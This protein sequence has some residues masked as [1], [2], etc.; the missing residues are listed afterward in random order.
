[1]LAMPRCLERLDGGA[2]HADHGVNVDL[3]DALVV[4][5]AH[6]MDISHLDNPRIVDE[7]IQAAIAVHGR[8][9]Q[10]LGGLRAAHIAVERDHRPNPRTR[11]PSRSRAARGARDHKA[12]ADSLPAQSVSQSHARCPVRHPSR[13][14][15]DPQGPYSRDCKLTRSPGDRKAAPA[16]DEFAVAH[17]AH[18]PASGGFTALEAADTVAAQPGRT[19]D[20]P[21]Y[22]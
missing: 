15:H 14:R 7:D 12:P 20:N 10:R 9:H 6:R 5:R 19:N 18:I 11:W 3:H 4:T 8:A 21:E 2:G 13:S 17:E 22:H 16:S 1:M